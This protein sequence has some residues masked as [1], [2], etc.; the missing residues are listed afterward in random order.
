MQRE[1]ELARRQID[2]EI[3]G[4]Q[5]AIW[6]LRQKR[7][8]LAPVNRIP[9]ELLAH[10]F[11][12]LQA[13]S[14]TSEPSINPRKRLEWI[15]V[16]RVCHRWYDAALFHPRLWCNIELFS[17]PAAQTMISRAKATPLIVRVHFP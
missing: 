1:L 7:N 4:H 16:L 10:I 15:V 6:T 12:H 8:A 9:L 14:A 13:I 17:T 3:S 2:A 11:A 5:K